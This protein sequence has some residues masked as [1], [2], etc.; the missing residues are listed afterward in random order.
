MLKTIIRW[1]TTDHIDWTQFEKKIYLRNEIHE[2]NE[3]EEQIHY[4]IYYYIPV[5]Y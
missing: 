4:H 3:R 2:L 5:I 1:L